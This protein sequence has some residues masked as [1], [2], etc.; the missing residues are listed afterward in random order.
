[1][2]SASPTV[3]G[4][5]YRLLQ[6]QN[7]DTIVLLS[8]RE[9]RIARRRFHDL[10]VGDRVGPAAWRCWIEKLK[11]EPKTEPEDGTASPA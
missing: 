1:M 9:I 11:E 7:P 4:M 3:R 5:R 10:Q 6:L 2:M 8:A